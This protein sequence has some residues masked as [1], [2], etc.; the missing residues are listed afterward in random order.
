M[1]FKIFNVYFERQK[2]LCFKYYL[3][4][5]LFFDFSCI[6]LFLN[7]FNFILNFFNFNF[8]LVIFNLFK[9]YLLE[10]DRD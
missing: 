3:Y 9:Y 1:R 7:F 4:I 5:S 8:K 2:E 10:M 6:F